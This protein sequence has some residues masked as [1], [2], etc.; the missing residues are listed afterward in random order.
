MTSD[1]THRIDA[2][3]ARIAHGGAYQESLATLR[4]EVCAREF[5]R[6]QG[7][8]QVVR[9]A[10]VLASF[11]R[12]K[13]IPMVSGDVLAG[14]Q[15]CYDFATP[16][17]LPCFDTPPAGSRLS[18]ETVPLALAAGVAGDDVAL[19]EEFLT[20]LEIGLIGTCLGGHVIGGYDR[21]LEMGFP[22]LAA[23]ARAET[24]A[25]AEASAIVMEA[26]SEYAYRYARRAEELLPT[27]SEEDRPYLQRIAEACEELSEGPARSFVQA[28]Q[29]VVLTHEILTA[30]QSCSSLSLGRVDQYLYPYYI[31][32]IAAGA[33]THDDA[34]ELIEAL[35]LKIGGLVQ[36]YQNVTLGGADI[37]GADQSNELTYLGLAATA[38]LKLDQPLVSLRCHA[39]MSDDLWESTLDLIGQGMG[40]PALFNDPVVREAKER[41]GIA[42][43]DAANYGIVGCVE[44][45]VPG[46]EW[47]QTEAVRLNWAK[48]LELMLN[49]GV[50][51]RT[52]KQTSF[53]SSCPLAELTTFEKFYDAFCEVFGRSVDLLARGTMVRDRGFGEVY[54]YPFL[55]S[56]MVGPLASGC[57]VSAGGAEYNALTM[58]SCGMADVVDSLM[59][60]KT[61]IYDDGAMTLDELATGL[62]TEFAD[63]PQMRSTLAGSGE[64]FGNGATDPDAMLVD[65]TARVHAQ[66][67]QYDPPR[68]GAWQMGL[69]TVDAHAYMGKQTGALASG[70][71]AGVSLANGCSPCQGADVHGPTAAVRSVTAL[72]HASLGNGMVFD[73]KFAPEW[74][75][76]DA[77]RGALRGLVQTYFVMG[78]M[79]IQFNV[80]DGETLRAA[81]MT[82]EAYR[83]L[84][85][86]VSGFSAYFTGLDPVTQDEII[87]RTQHGEID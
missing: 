20:G 8:A 48:V 22:A 36:S 44:M 73:L 9:A 30:E 16:M 2:L 40:F 53:A 78:G 31:A 58:N 86:R 21:V 47:A 65:L 55:S 17:D 67:A 6:S 34:R 13:E 26:A 80:V 12:D 56:T 71:P 87:A 41:V 42:R 39:G 29:S 19:M 76:S 61:C 52:G 68:G 10:K 14:H 32:D 70:R 72:D 60:I 77:G 83:D 54:P 15:Q 59:A 49:E 35:W 62:R 3:R 74:V 37:D 18:K 24:G 4:A 64:R 28:V 69:Y 5:A 57:D 38:R 45:T 50:C 33:L 51:T 43:A 25:F 81:Q 79:E 66:L 7:E 63:A 82:P 11:L 85:V 46:K 75:K 23:E 84:I 1:S 27:A